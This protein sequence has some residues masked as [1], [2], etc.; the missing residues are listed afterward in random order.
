MTPYFVNLPLGYMFEGLYLD[1]FLEQGVCPEVGLESVD[2]EDPATFS[3]ARELAG[4]FHA[5]GLRC[6]VH[7]P[8]SGLSLFRPGATLE[9]CLETARRAL[10]AARLF[11][12][13]RMVGHPE[14]PRGLV[15]PSGEAVA[16]CA[17]LWTG[18]AELN[19]GGPPIALEN[20]FETDP[21]AGPAL[22][23]AVD[24]PEVGACF[25]VGHWHSFAG[26]AVRRDLDRWVAAVAPWLVH[27][28]LHDN[29][30]GGDD[31]LGLGAGAVDWSEVQQAL[32][33]VPGPLTATLEP[34]SQE[35]YAR[36][37]R[38]LE[39]VPEL[40]AIFDPAG[41]AA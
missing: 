23:A 7:L 36:S 19:R 10:E 24:R 38:F 21:Q 39:A 35:D 12:P 2:L 1:Q 11:R 9:S 16:R 15:D 37:L 17:E 28:H 41:A 14:L 25:D 27:V 40:L 20:T 6:T 26:G 4:R 22:L 8:W 29:D 3:R 13:V 31:H 5:A 18:I 34:H 32:R 33:S 30:G